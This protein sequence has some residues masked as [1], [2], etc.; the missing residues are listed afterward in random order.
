MLNRHHIAGLK[1]IEKG[2]DKIAS[3]RFLYSFPLSLSL[4]A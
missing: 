4:T 3:S 2:E 1:K